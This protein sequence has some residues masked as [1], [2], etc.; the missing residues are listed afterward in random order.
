MRIARAMRLAALAAVAAMLSTAALAQSYP[1]RSITIV[2]VFAAGGPSDTLA[3]LLG[4]HLGRQF[5]QQIIIENV[6][7]AGGTTGTERAAKA[8]P[9]GYTILTHHGGL[10]AAPALYS[11]LRFDSKTAFEPMG[12]INTGPMALISRKT[13]ETKTL[14]ELIA[15]AKEKG[16]K[17]TIG[18][19]GVGSNSFVCATLF[20]Q[21]IGAKLS[22]VPYRGTGPAMTDIVAG[23]ID[24]LC[25]QATTAV[26]QIQA[27][28]V[29]AYVVTSAQRL[30]SLPDVPSNAEAGLPGFQHTIWNAAYAP[31]GTPKEVIE[32]WNEAIGKFVTDPA[33]AER[34]AAT[35][36]V[37]F[38][39]EMR[40]PA[41]HAKWLDEQFDFF[42]NMFAAANVKKQEVK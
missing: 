40:T 37:P 32:R 35:G 9:D 11:N 6:A 16:D 21:Q 34:F 3:R 19:A 23:Q 41:A 36:T 7:G 4:D 31:K 27:G 42:A 22:M 26:P 20:Q 24:L 1:N 18:F 10:T 13:L 25:D 38:P 5:G 39:P 28:T 2:V 14:A 17:A 8:P 15:W 29:K 30:A 12:L 33:I